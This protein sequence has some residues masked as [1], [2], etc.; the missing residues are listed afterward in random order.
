[1]VNYNTLGGQSI[2]GTMREARNK[3]RL[4]TAQ[5][6]EDFT[7]ENE[8]TQTQSTLLDSQYTKTDALDQIIKS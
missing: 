8:V 7:L 5:I 3:Q 6:S 4:D 1:V 2:I